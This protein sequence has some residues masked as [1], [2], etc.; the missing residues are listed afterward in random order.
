MAVRSSSRDAR[1]MTRFHRIAAW[2]VIALLVV[3]LVATLV[4]DASA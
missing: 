2:V 1:G 4:V 3:T